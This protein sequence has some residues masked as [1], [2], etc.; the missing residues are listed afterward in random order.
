MN[1]YEIIYK[2]VVVMVLGALL[3]LQI[4]QNKH[5]KERLDIAEK[6]ESTFN[7]KQL[8]EQVKSHKE[9]I[10]II[11]EQSKTAEIEKV[12]RELTEKSKQIKEPER[13]YLAAFFVLSILALKLDPYTRKKMLELIEFLEKDIAQDL[14]KEL[15]EMVPNKDKERIRAEIS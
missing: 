15:V 11:T 10:E 14:R 2:I 9:L 7:I 8:L 5:L 4:K 3:Y 6:W 1:A 13:K 12:K